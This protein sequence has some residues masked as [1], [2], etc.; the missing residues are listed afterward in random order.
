MKTISFGI[1]TAL[2]FMFF[3]F[4]SANYGEKLENKATKGFA[5]VELFT[6]EGCSSCPPADAA[7]AKLLNDHTDNVYVLGFHVDYW[8]YLGWRDNFSDAAYS[9]RQ[10]R[11]SRVFHL[12]SVYTPQIIVNGSTQFVGSNEATLRR[13]VDENL[14]KPAT[15]FIYLSAESKGSHINVAYTTNAN[16]SDQLNIALVQLN[17]ASKVER[18]EN[19]GKLLHHV[20]VVRDLKTINLQSLTGNVDFILPQ[21]ASPDNFMVI[22][23]TQSQNS[24]KISAGAKVKI[25]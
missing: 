3:S 14:A 4:A 15:T 21:T 12:E 10:E 5:V 11:Y 17:A 19:A 22:A 20:N 8:N 23:F 25:D 2:F 18:G 9:A 24:L 16:S 13:T 7:V 1:A 6:S